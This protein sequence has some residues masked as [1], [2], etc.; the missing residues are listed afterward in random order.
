MAQ[1]RKLEHLPVLSVARVITG[2]LSGTANLVVALLYSGY[3]KAELGNVWRHPRGG[4][5]LL[6]LIFTGVLSLALARSA[7][8]VLASDVLGAL[9]GSLFVWSQLAALSIGLWLFVAGL[10][11]FLCATSG[12]THSAIGLFRLG[13]A[14]ALG[15]LA[16]VLQGRLPA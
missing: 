9:G 6:T 13:I 12:R 16:G 14:L 11:A 10:L 4:V 15:I 8:H 7:Q 2:A 5:L 1:R 3:A